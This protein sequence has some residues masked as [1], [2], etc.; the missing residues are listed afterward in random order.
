MKTYTITNPTEW[1]LFIAAAHETVP[2]FGGA[3]DVE[4]PDDVASGIAATGVLRVT[5]VPAPA[6]DG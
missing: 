5:E 1:P 2:G 4:L 6:G 3:I